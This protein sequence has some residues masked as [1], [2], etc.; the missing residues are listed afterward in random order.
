MY[1]GITDLAEILG[2]TTSAIRF[3]EE[4]HLISA[5]KTDN[6]RRYYTEEDV[7]RL[8]SYTKYR[9]MGIPMKTIVHQFSGE[10]NNWAIIRKRVE[11]SKENS[12]KKAEYYRQLSENIE[13]HLKGIK[14]IGNLLGKYEFEKCPACI[15][16]QDDGCG[17]L[18]KKR[19]NQEAVRLLVSDMPEV[20]LAVLQQDDGDP[21]FGYM[22]PQDSKVIAEV[23]AKLRQTVIRPVSCIHTVVKALEDFSFHPQ[24]V[25]DEIKAY[26]DR[27]EFIPNGKAWGNILLVEVEKEQHLHPYV[28]LWLPII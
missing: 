24:K 22:V 19:R 17:W 8:L 14:L 9:S 10:E 20:Q 25:F 12:I 2:I 7:F 16:M 23:C 4:E 5:G 28:E 11:D 27:R 21:D 6:G 15:I 3:F 1:Y 18:S 13:R 26:A